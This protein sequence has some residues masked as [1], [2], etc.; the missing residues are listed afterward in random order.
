MGH[1][2][3]PDRVSAADFIRGFASWRLQSARRPV[4][5]TH[6]GKDAHV[7]IS[8]DDYRR[9]G[10]DGCQSGN[11]RLQESQILLLESVR[12]C[13]ILIDREQRIAALNPAASD[14]FEIAASSLVGQPLVPALPMLET[15]V[16][17][18]HI[19]RMIDHRERFTGE[20]PS[21]LRPGQ[22][23]RVDLIPL[24]V[25]GAIVLR[26][27]SETILAR[28]AADAQ[29]AVIRALDIDGGIGHALLSVRETIDYANP[30]LTEMIGANEQAIRRVRFSALLPLAARNQF[31]EA[32]ETL[33]R[34][35][36]PLRQASELLS[37][38]GMPVPVTL[39]IV[40]RRGT[41]G[42][43]GAAILVTRR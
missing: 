18:P 9:L 15:S 6:H 23:L 19:L 31:A 32:F 16:L 13:V 35:G 28:E 17:F 3:I 1:G 24:P 39:S 29:H 14:M 36:A 30:A 8:L 42:S 2:Q 7:L 11:G 33:F 27:I 12:D 34:T 21:L 10:S 41:Y 22:W 20:L 40:E 43:E 25:G 38:E 5:V 4:V 26:D 37:R